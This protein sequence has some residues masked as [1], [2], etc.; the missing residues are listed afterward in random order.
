MILVNLA[1]LANKRNYILLIEIQNIFVPFEI[2]HVDLW[3]LFYIISLLGHTYFLTLVD[4][5]SRY[6]WAIFLKSKHQVKSSIIQFI[7]YI[8]N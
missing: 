2:L 6:T 5:Y 1:I 3:G 7:T 4:D 8:E